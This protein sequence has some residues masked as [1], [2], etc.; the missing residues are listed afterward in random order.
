MITVATSNRTL[1]EFKA[2]RNNVFEKRSGIYAKNLNK[3]NQWLDEIC[4][5]WPLDMIDREVWELRLRITK[6]ML[7]EQIPVR[8]DYDQLVSDL[9]AIH[10]CQEEFIDC[11]NFWRPPPS[12]L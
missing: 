12:N 2:F 10:C 1:E 11:Q 9:N 4:A 5:S 8:P 6:R 7:S 3:T